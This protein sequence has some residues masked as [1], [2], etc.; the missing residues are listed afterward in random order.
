MGFFVIQG[1]PDKPWNIMGV[2]HQGLLILE[3]DNFDLL[4]T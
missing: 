4:F 1:I 3:V 2:F